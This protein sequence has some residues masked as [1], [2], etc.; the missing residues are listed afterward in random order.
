MALL[1]HPA[2]PPAIELVAPVVAPRTHVQRTNLDIKEAAKGICHGTIGVPDPDQTAALFVD[3]LGFGH[4]RRPG[5]ET[6]EL[7][8]QRPLSQWSMSLTIE[9][10]SSGADF[11]SLD[12]EGWFVLALLSSD[13]SGDARCVQKHTLKSVTQPF[14]TE[15]S[16]QRWTIVLCVLNSGF[17]VEL[18]QLASGH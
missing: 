3:A 17:A 9:E 15:V 2:R 18:L 14:V 11:P 8:L 7:S 16:G 10:D 1:R 13:I 12:S 4:Q 5:S 6:V